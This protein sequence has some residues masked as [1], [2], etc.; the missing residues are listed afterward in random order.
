MIFDFEQTAALA[1]VRDLTLSGPVELTGAGLWA[2]VVSSGSCA[3]QTGADTAGPGTLILARTT[4]AL[5]AD[6]PCH[7]LAVRMT[8]TAAGSFAAALPTD[9][10]FARGDT[11]PGAAE[12]LGELRLLWQDPETQPRIQSQMVFA[13]LCE[14]AAA[15]SAQTPLPALVAEAMDHI[16]K[17]YA[18]LYGVEE[19]SEYL[20]VS[21]SHLVRAFGA[22]VGVSPGKYLTGVR[23]NAAKRLLLHREYNLEIVASLCGFSGANYLCR[24][25]KKE[26]GMTPA[27]W[28]SMAASQTASGLSAEQAAREQE[29][30]I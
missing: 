17:N 27:A 6:A 23:I 24:V 13:L 26:T 8:G 29:L 1:E 16:H 19:L 11:C 9:L 2:A 12:L 4:L 15:D 25:F 22:A 7:L 14:L 21:K 18:G 28:R 10:F 5:T 20:G 3:A 30:Y